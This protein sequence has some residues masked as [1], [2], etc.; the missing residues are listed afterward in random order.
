MVAAGLWLLGPGFGVV[1]ERVLRSQLAG[2]GLVGDYT[3]EEMSRSGVTMRDLDLTGPGLIRSV[4]GEALEVHYRLGELRHGQIRSFNARNFEIVLDLDAAPEREAVQFDADALGHTLR[5]AQA[6]LGPV[7]MTAEN[8]TIHI[9]RGD[10]PVTSIR[11]ADITHE[12]ETEQFHVRFEQIGSEGGEITTHPDNNSPPAE[13]IDPVVD[14]LE[15]APRQNVEVTWGPEG[16]MID[17]LEILPGLVLE[18]LELRHAE[19]DPLRAE[20]VARIDDAVLRVR[21][22]DNLRLAHLHLEE[23]TIDLAALLERLGLDVELDGAVDSLELTIQNV[24]QPPGMW[25]ATGNVTAPRLGHGDWWVEGVGL[26][27]EKAAETTEITLNG[28]FAGTTIRMVGQA[29]LQEEFAEDAGRWWH[30]AEAEGWIETDG[31]APALAELRR[32]M[33]PDAAEVPIPQARLEMDFAAALDGAEM[34]RASADFTLQDL[35]INGQTM[36]PLSG[37]AAWD[38]AARS[39]DVALRHLN[40]GEVNVQGT[41][42]FSSERY[43]GSANFSGYE[44]A[45]LA[46]FLRPFDVELPSGI[47]NGS[48]TGSGAFAEINRHSGF[49]QLQESQLDFPDRPPLGGTLEATYDWPG[50]VGMERVRI[51]QDGRTFELSGSWRAGEVVLDQVSFLGTDEE[52]LLTGQ[53]RLPLAPDVRSM[54]DFFAQDGEISAVF[55]ASDLAL[56]QIR[57]LLPGV[58]PPGSGLISVTLEIAGTLGE[59]VAAANLSLQGVTLEVFPELVPSDVALRAESADGRL[60]VDSVLLQEGEAIL[61]VGADI[62]L[63]TGL[64]SVEDFL[65]QEESITIRLETTDFPVEQLRQFLP[66]GF[67]ELP[68]SGTLDGEVT[69][70][71]TFDEPTIE[72]R[73]EVRDLSL[74]PAEAEPAVELG[75]VLVR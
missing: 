55:E 25:N 59:P 33:D 6:Q 54:D 49:I 5:T 32:Q 28:A 62:P 63:T 29:T 53:A 60:E 58:D 70:T 20:S 48:W 1:G 42:A 22:E 73:I 45:A 12:A 66:E 13:A 74:V 57:D 10:E 65:A 24:L 15:E 26:T 31:L 40:E 44:L 7:D 52:V 9:V 64:R 51:E 18:N 27:L 4:T 71:G 17:R 2:A 14:L 61:S 36:P 68:E 3:V 75:A 69:I 38:T 43:Q 67:L 16:L 11:G 72:A 37:E 21:L 56:A 23:G 8:V 34:A 41:W 35:A 30:G 39:V 46:G 47:L 50:E 19:D